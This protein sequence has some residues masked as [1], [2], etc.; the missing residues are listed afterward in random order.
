MSTKTPSKLEKIMASGQLGVTSEV[1]PPRGADGAAL[2][3]CRSV[4]GDGAKTVEVVGH[5]HA[6]AGAVAEVFRLKKLYPAFVRNSATSLTLMLPP[7]AER[8]TADCPARNHILP[9]YLD[10]DRFVTPFCCYGNDVDCNRC[11]AWAVFH[12][13]ARLDPENK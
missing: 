7:H 10:G 8:V 6:R 13:A 2:G 11:G 1:G 4:A 5:Q 3:V 12:L 9:L